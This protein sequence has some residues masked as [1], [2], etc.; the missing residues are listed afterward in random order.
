M[1]IFLS[2]HRLITNTVLSS[3]QACYSGRKLYHTMQVC[4]AANDKGVEHLS[5]HLHLVDEIV[6]R[7]QVTV[8]KQKPFF[9]SINITGL[10]QTEF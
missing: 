7:K 10:V 6:Q 1:P 8:S 9:P 3:G 2:L 5:E 4:R